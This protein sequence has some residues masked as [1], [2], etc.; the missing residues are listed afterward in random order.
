MTGAGYRVHLAVSGTQVIRYASHHLPNILIVDPDLPDSDTLSLLKA[1]RDD[2]PHLPVII[3]T[4]ISDYADHPDIFNTAVWVEKG[5]SSA[6]RL[7][8]AV[9]KLLLSA[10]IKK[11]TA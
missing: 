10:D 6:E 8:E 7:K 4:F 11:E 5:E 3:H 9:A 2:L 1:L